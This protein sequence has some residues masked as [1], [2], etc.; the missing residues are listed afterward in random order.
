MIPS[1]VNLST[2]PSKRWTPSQRIAK[3][4]SMI[5]LPLLGVALLGELHR[6]HHVGEQHRHLL[7][8]ALERAAAGADLLGEVLRGRGERLAHGRAARA[9]AHRRTAASG[10]IRC[11]IS[12]PARSRYRTRRTATP[13]SA[14]PRTPRR[15]VLRR[16]SRGR[17]QSRSHT[18]IICPAARRVKLARPRLVGHPPSGVWPERFSWLCL[19]MPV[20]GG[21]TGAARVLVGGPASLE[22]PVAGQIR[23][24]GRVACL[25]G[26]RAA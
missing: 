9:R 13:W 20:V 1:P 19:Q 16:R 26:S 5:R 15:T 11:R 6:A 2:V 14:P 18:A 10:R 8:L 23:L 7:A 24:G 3:K 21:V 12:V 17:R 4:R 25:E 22:H